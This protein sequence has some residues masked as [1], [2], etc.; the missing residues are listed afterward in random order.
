LQSLIDGLANRGYL[1]IGPTVGDGAIVY[2]TV[3]FLPVGWT[4]KQNAGR[5]RLERR[6]DAALFG[7]AVGPY[8]WKRSL[9]PSIERL[10]QVR[11]QGDGFSVVEND[12]AVEPL[13]FVGVR[14][15]ELRAIAI[16][17]RVFLS[18]SHRD[19]SY[20]VRRDHAFIV[21]VNCSR[22]AA[23]VFAFRWMPERRSKRVSTSH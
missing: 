21:A 19:K 7:Y 2:D 20:R 13:T 22:R 6:A 1:V 9:H 4:D 5:Y 18:G 17:D 11:R 10:W 16:N 12:E 15:C 23:P 3:A 8:S 14:A